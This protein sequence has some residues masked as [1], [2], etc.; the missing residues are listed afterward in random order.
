MHF[1]LKINTIYSVSFYL[2]VL[3]FVSGCMLPGSVIN[4]E[5]FETNLTSMKLAEYPAFKVYY[6]GSIREIPLR[7]VKTIVIDP[8]SMIQFE[9]ELYYGAEILLK[10]GSGIFSTEKDK[11]NR[12]KTFI[13]I[14]NVLLG[15]R[16]REFFRINLGSIAQLDVR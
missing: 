5:Q 14:Q 9:N 13:S 2:S 15:K 6:G 7:D 11:T 3:F 8:S 4:H 12:T 1:K 10:D 16:D